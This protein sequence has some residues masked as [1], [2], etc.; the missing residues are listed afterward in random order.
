M[1]VFV[2]GGF[3]ALHIAAEEGHVHMTSLLLQRGAPASCQSH[4][5]LTALHLAAQE[6][7]LPVARTLVETGRAGVDATT[8]VSVDRLPVCIFEGE[9]AQLFAAVNDRVCRVSRA[10]VGLGFIAMNNNYYAV[11]PLPEG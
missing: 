4:N 9:T 5:G 11:L 6:D 8:K 3:S 7:H 1:V 10:K 2:Q